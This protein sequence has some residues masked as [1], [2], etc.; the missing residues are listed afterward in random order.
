MPVLLY[1]QWSEH[2]NIALIT[3][4]SPPG[5]G[6]ASIR[7][8]SKKRYTHG[9]FVLDIK[10][11]PGSNC[12]SW[13][14][15]W[16]VDE[17]GWPTWGEID[18]I[19]GVNLQSRNWATLHTRPGCFVNL[20]GSQPGTQLMNGDCNFDRAYQGCSAHTDAPFGDLFNRGLGG[21]YATQWESSGIYIWFFPRNKI[22]VDISSGKPDTTKWGL[23]LVAFNGGSGCNIDS[24]FGNHEIVFDT[25]FCGDVS[26][27]HLSRYEAILTMII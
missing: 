17:R 13:P 19:E 6:R 7:V 8:Q 10:H 3:Q 22:P 11:M 16:L 2:L 9:L 5:R 1:I 20:A 18:I 12:G 14:A 27:A 4:S 21:V 26:T 24:Y 23:P 25:T 15:Y